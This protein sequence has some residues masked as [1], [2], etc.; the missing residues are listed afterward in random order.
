[1]DFF[2]IEG[3][4]EEETIQVR[5]FR[6]LAARI[7]IPIHEVKG[8]RNFE[9]IESHLRLARNF[10]FSELKKTEG[11]ADWQALLQ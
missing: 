3:F 8:G 11:P 5:S 2:S 10:F 4:V 7:S 1:M 6:K 9:L